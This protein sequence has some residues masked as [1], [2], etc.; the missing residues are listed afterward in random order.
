MR[1]SLAATDADQ[2]FVFF[3]ILQI[4]PIMSEIIDTPLFSTVLR[5]H[6]S[7]SLSGFRLVMVLVAG[8]SA[9]AAIPFIVM[10]FWPVAGFYGLDV[11]LLYFAFRVNF[12]LQNQSEEII[13][14]PFDLALR[15]V[16]ENGKAQEWHFNPVWT[17]LVTEDHPEF[18]VMK[19][20]LASRNELV[21]LGQFLPPEDRSRLIRSVSAALSEA[22]RGPIHS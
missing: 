5:P 13:I 6:R 21:P 4:I 8:A 15:K 2:T 18:G 19:L 10:G 16:S 1:F 3:S 14:S 12:K 11:A 17:R 7:L 22:K 9:V 20:A